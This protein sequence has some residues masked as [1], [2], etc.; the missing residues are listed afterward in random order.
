MARPISWLPRL[1]EIRR[2]VTNSVRSHYTRGELEILFLIQP[3]A[4]SRL[5]EI[6][7]TVQVGTSNLVERE[8]LAAFLTRIAD[9]ED[10]TAELDKIR[11]ERAGVTRK[12]IRSLVRR[13]R[14]Q[15][16]LTG[17]PSSLKLRP[18]RVQIDYESMEELGSALL[19]LALILQDD[20]DEFA[21][22]YEIAP[23][24]PP[25]D[26]AAEEVRQMFERLREMELAR[27]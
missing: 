6:L 5:L 23:E 3:R 24:L 1:H 16:S 27:A 18:G 4:A 17:L 25:E 11:R 7:P 15:A 14:Y 9:A 12:K 20:G 21:R 10:V 13:D 8:A 2:S 19:A 26:N 22:L